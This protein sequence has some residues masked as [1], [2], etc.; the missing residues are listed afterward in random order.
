MGEFPPA[1]APDPEN[2]PGKLPALPDQHGS[3]AA[4]PGTG[5][6]GSQDTLP[7]V[8]AGGV[9]ES[10]QAL[11]PQYDTTPPQRVHVEVLGVKPNRSLPSGSDGGSTENSQTRS[12]VTLAAPVVNPGRRQIEIEAAPDH[13][14]HV[15]GSAEELAEGQRI[16]AEEGEEAYVKYVESRH[17]TTDKSE[18][19]GQSA[20]TEVERRSDETASAPNEY[21]LYNVAVKD[22]DGKKGGKGE[23]DPYD[24]GPSSARLRVILDEMR[25]KNGGSGSAEVDSTAAST[26]GAEQNQASPETPQDAANE[27]VRD[28]VISEA[29]RKKGD[30][31]DTGV[32]S[33]EKLAELLGKIECTP[34]YPD[35]NAPISY[36]IAIGAFNGD[37]EGARTTFKELEAGQGGDIDPSIPPLVEQVIADQTESRAN[38]EQPGWEEAHRLDGEFRNMDREMGLFQKARDKYIELSALQRGNH[39]GNLPSAG[40]KIREVKGIFQKARAIAQKARVL[41]HPID[42]QLSKRAE[43]ELQS[44]RQDF[45]EATRAMAKYRTKFTGERNQANE[46]HE[47]LF[48]TGVIDG[49]EAAIT[50]QQISNAESRGGAENSWRDKQSARLAKNWL[51]PAKVGKYGRIGKVLKVGLTAG[52]TGVAVGTGVALFSP[53]L[54]LAAGAYAGGE[55]AQ[56]YGKVV[57][58]YGV[59]TESE[60]ARLKAEGNKRTATAKLDVNLV[61]S[62]PDEFDVS[63]SI[64]RGNK[65]EL[66]QNFARRERMR[67]VGRLAG[68]LGARAA[69]D[70]VVSSS[71]RGAAHSSGGSND[72]LGG[73]KGGHT[74][75][76]LPGNQNATPVPRATPGTTH[77]SSG[78]VPWRAAN[79]EVHAG[80]LPAGHEMG[81]V[82][83]AIKAHN[84]THTDQFGLAPTPDGKFL[85]VV[86]ADGSPLNAAA[87]ASFDQILEQGVEAG[88]I[89]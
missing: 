32:P 14:R 71:P 47:L 58:K 5:T 62:N 61:T 74:E 88:T 21:E 40:G 89:R 63:K 15:V 50:R 52:A 53:V 57:N 22:A 54:A 6:E 18:T 34:L 28:F 70:M 86:H 81:A 35:G 20:S 48:Q 85:Q 16:F 30:G 55:L 46:K 25:G 36:V 84:L 38:W 56:R 72:D 9:A 11:S 45:V 69:A 67:M 59:L 3:E 80:N 19:E 26:G 31:V 37:T 7:A 49:T 66:G 1:Q 75:A 78:D 65:Q 82:R 4:V 41:T 68:S 77:V 13:P 42:H 23:K 2:D 24:D 27:A 10:G 29:L 44:A 83:E 8:Y 79:L 39:L 76:G 64:E 73:S 51:K 17:N 43:R 87:Q 60:Q 12:A 33:A